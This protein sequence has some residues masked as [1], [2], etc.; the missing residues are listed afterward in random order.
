VTAVSGTLF[1]RIR[2][3]HFV[4]IGGTGMS[5]IAEI[6]LSLGYEVSG[7]DLSLTPVTERLARRGA[8]VHRGH[9]AANIEGAQVVVVS[10]AIP[11]GN[12]EVEAARNAQVPVIPRSEML[13]ELMRMKHGVAVAGTHG[14][15]ST[16]CL[17]AHILE[18]AGLDPTV[19]VGGR[20]NVLGSGARLGTSDL[21]VCE[22]DESDG[23]F[24]RLSPTVA[25]ATNVD[26]EHLD[27]YGGSLDRLH[28][29]FA[30]FLNNVP[31]Y[32]TAVVCLD[33]PA[34]QDLIPRIGR[35]IVTYGYSAQADVRGGHPSFDRF[36][37]RVEVEIRGEPA[38]ELRLALPGR[39]YLQNALAA[40]AVADYLG[41]PFE[42]AREAVEDFQGAGRRFES[43][44]E[45][46]GVLVI[47][48]YA[49]HPTEIRATLEAVRAGFDR[50]VLAVFQ[51]HRYS[52]VRDCMDEFQR[53]FYEA[54]LVVVT[55]IYP[56]GE[57]PQEGAT[58]EALFHGIVEHGHKQAVLIKD[59]D[60]VVAHL[61]KTVREGDLVLT[62]GA[63]DITR[64][65]D[66]LVAALAGRG[67]S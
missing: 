29:A 40:V 58:A 43:K 27:A 1:G 17:L 60:E 30:D 59:L 15:T 48:D 46:A 57:E 53:S 14:K 7:S 66:A 44:G 19:I 13:A 39:H 50:R 63:G 31:F 2:R 23:S 65:S 34:L 47:D 10:T 67:A 28:Q 11:E 41:V 32:G 62:L 51:P 20:L 36:H 55:E 64:V 49:H 54:D 22:A 16:T 37:S 18:R 61:E 45:V 5:G 6:L 35:P 24:L 33:D 3:I 21:L 42:K 56:A 9:E 52:R 4:G 12:A 38:G 8:V 25:V 26:A